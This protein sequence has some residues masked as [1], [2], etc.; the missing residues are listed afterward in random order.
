MIP[1][2]TV[3]EQK[4]IN[5]ITMKSDGKHI[6]SYNVKGRDENEQGSQFQDYFANIEDNINSVN[7]EYV[8]K[9]D[10]FSSC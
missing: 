2:V 9:L 8:I 1:L 5:N 7:V 6:P 10:S 4:D 3:L